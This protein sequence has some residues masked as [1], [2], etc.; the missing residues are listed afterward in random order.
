MADEHIEVLRNNDSS[1]RELHLLPPGKTAPIPDKDKFVS[2]YRVDM[3]MGAYVDLDP[4]DVVVVDI[5]L[6]G[7]AGPALTQPVWSQRLDRL[8]RGIKLA[9]AELRGG[10]CAVVR[11][12]RAFRLGAVT[13]G[14]RHHQG[15]HARESQEC[16]CPRSPARW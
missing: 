1:V 14:R 10:E 3:P 11:L 15:R 5:D 4:A 16:A 6:N 2:A 13:A 8:E 7:V 12:G 9:L